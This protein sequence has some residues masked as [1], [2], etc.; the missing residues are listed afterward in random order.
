VVVVIACRYVFQI[1]NEESDRACTIDEIMDKV[2]DWYE[3][4]E[5]GRRDSDWP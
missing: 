2:R 3:T 1:Y 5:M 4:R